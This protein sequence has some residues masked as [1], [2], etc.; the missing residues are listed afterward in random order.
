MAPAVSRTGTV[1]KRCDRSNHKADSNKKCADGTCQHTCEPGAIERCPHAWTLR[2]WVNDRQVE[3]SFKD[4][5]RG[6]RVIYG[7][8]KKLAQDFQLQTTVDKR[9]GDITFADH[10][11]TAKQNFGEACE[12]YVSRLAVGE[13]SKAQYLKN[14]RKHI[15]PGFGDSTLAQVAK[16]RDGVTDLLAVTMKDK[17]LSVRT[18]T[19]LVIVGTCDEAVKSGKLSRHFLAGIEL[20]DNGPKRLQSDFV[21]PT[22]AQVATV[23][24]GTVN[25][26]TGRALQGAG[27]SVW[28]MRGCGLRIEE[29]LA[30]CEGGFQGER[31]HPAGDV[32]GVPRWTLKVSAQ[33]P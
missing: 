11:R 14:Y 27:I 16:D 26:E 25:P 3:K 19:R 29:A 8:G 4:E 6:G 9:A 23:A 1:F 17:S 33:A 18:I 5:V 20:A 15:K 12:A 21:F 13:S 24:G 10:G 32:A 22:H 2:Y 7:S 28:L 31:Q 30:V